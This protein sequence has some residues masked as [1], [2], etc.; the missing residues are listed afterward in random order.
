MNTRQLALILLLVAAA[1]TFLTT[2]SPPI[3]TSTSTPDADTAFWTAYAACQPKLG[4]L[5][6]VL[7]SPTTANI[8]T[9]YLHNVGASASDLEECWATLPIPALRSFRAVRESL[10]Q[11]ATLY[12][13]SA[14]ELGDYCA[15]GS[16]ASL[17]AATDA[18]NRANDILENIHHLLDLHGG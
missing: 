16:D 12:R 14:D 11:A 4:A 8:C 7:A 17:D 13:V 18:L 15:T 10:I 2:C 6:A 5:Q 1:G 3:P 9:D